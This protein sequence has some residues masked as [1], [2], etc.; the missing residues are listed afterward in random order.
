MPRGGPQGTILGM[1]LF[2]VYI[3]PLEFDSGDTIGEKMS[4][5]LSKRKSLVNTHLKYVDDM[6]LAESIELKE[7]LKK[8][9]RSIDFPVTFHRRTGHYLP[10]G[11]SKMQNKL[12]EIQN[13]ALDND[14]KINID[15]TKVMFLNTSTKFDFQPEFRINGET[16]EV[17]E[18]VKLLGVIF[19]SDL[20][21][22]S[23][24]DFICKKGFN[25]LYLLRRLKKIGANRDI[26]KDMY[27]KQVRPV[28]EYAVPVW[29]SSITSK[30]SQEI[31]RIQ[32]SALSIIYGSQAYEKLLM[33]SGL[34]TLSDRRE[35]L[36]KKFTK[37][38]CQNDVCDDWFKKSKISINTRQRAKKFQEIQART[39]RFHKSPIPFMSRLANQ[40][41]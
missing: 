10:S 9:D 3:N 26:L 37:K 25:K 8:E 41:I 12:N 27:I 23:N 19:T 6:T 21:F 17:V 36:I 34:T 11:E 38:V 22:Q 13:F 29:G 35:N 24:T 5:Q 20:K 39:N 15:K 32:K 30:E 7:K 4:G 31:E 40:I 33:K 18:G 2:I 16:L 14:M 1:F 28:A